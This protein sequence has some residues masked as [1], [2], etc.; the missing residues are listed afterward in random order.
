SAGVVPLGI[1]SSPVSSWTGRSDQ[2]ASISGQRE[3]SNSYLLDGIETRNS[4]F[5][6]TGIRPS[7]DAIQE[8]RIQ[9]NTFSSEFGHGTAVINAAIKS[10][11]NEFHGSVFEFL[12]N[13]HFDARNFFDLGR[14][15]PFQQNNFGATFSGPMRRNKAFFFGNYEGFRQR[16]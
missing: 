12:R 15:P 3:S 2:S 9:R 14:R 1:G 8:F 6:S 11:G 13:N 4:R 16:L 10:G 7:I 5:G